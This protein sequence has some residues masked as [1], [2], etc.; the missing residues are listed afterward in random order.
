METQGIKRSRKR[1]EK[2]N[3]G[4]RK[5]ETKILPKMEPVTETGRGREPGKDVKRDPERNREPPACPGVWNG[6]KATEPHMVI[7]V[8]MRNTDR[9]YAIVVYPPAFFFLSP[10]RFRWMC[11]SARAL[12]SLSP[13]PTRLN[14][15]RR[16]GLRL[17]I[18]SI[19]REHA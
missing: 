15:R 5:T 12:L 3:Q 11:G 4:K 10:E 17:A 14:A 6:A 1:R 7:W 9:G 2:S 13:V 18:K 19:P 16:V 8:S